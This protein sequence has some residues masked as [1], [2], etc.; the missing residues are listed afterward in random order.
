V[1]LR[2]GGYWFPANAVVMTT[3]VTAAVTPANRV[4]A[5][6]HVWDFQGTLFGAPGLQGA[7]LQRN[8][9]A[10]QALLQRALG[11]QNRDVVL[12]A[13]DGTVARQL[14]NATST[15]GVRVTGPW[16]PQGNGAQFAGYL[17]FAFRAEAQYAVAGGQRFLLSFRETVNFEGG[18]P[19]FAHLQPVNDLPQKQMIYQATPYRATQE[20]EASGVGGYPFVPPPLWPGALKKAPR[21]GRTSPRWVGRTW[22]EYPVSWGYEYESATPLANLGPHPWPAE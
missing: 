19:L 6:D 18:G 10:Q 8:L 1:Q 2:Y 20:G 7:A 15:T 22:L 21:S 13:D 11:L 17:D 5:E 12:Y 3:A 14:P 16:F 9:I 4:Y